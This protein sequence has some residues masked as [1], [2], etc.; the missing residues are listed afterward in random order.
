MVYLPSSVV[1]KC[2]FVGTACCYYGKYWF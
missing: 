1:W 2:A